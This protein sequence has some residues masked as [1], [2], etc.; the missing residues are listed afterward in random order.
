MGMLLERSIV[1]EIEGH[2]YRFEEEAA[3]IEA[4]LQETAE[5]Y[6]FSYVRVKVSGGGIADPVFRRTERLMRETGTLKGWNSVVKAAAARFE[7]TQMEGFIELVYLK[8][9]SVVSVCSELFID[10]RT[11]YKWR[12]NLLNYAAM[13]ACGLGLIS[14]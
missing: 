2:F 8:K 1:K 14:V 6:D 9:R 4:L 10:R 7:G 13:K 5:A 11:Y 12:E 3:E